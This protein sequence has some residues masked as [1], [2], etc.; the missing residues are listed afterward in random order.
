M[1]T[2]KKYISLL[3]SAIM[4]LGCTASLAEATPPI[5]LSVD[6]LQAAGGTVYTHDGRVTFV[7]GTCA[8]GPVKDMDAA[9]QVV[10]DMAA[11]LGCDENTQFEPWRTVLDAAGNIYYVFQ[12]MYHGTTVSGGAVKVVTDAS[13]DMLGL[14]S[15]VESELPDVEAAEGISAEEAEA[16]VLEH[17]EQADQPHA[18][19]IAGCTQMA[20]LPVN[21]MLDPYSEEEKEESRFVWVVYTDNPSAGVRGRSELP[22]LAHYV[23]TGG[24]YLYSLPTIIPGDEA[25][26]SGYDAS[27]VFEFMEPVDYADTVQLS[28]GTEA[29]ISVTLMRDTRTGMY[30]MGNIERRIVVADCYEFLYDEGRVV[31]E[32]SP[33]NTGWDTGCLLA[34]CNYCR[35]WDF[36]NEIGWHGGDGLGT[37][38]LIL[39]DYCNSDREPI[40]NAAYAGKYYGWQV[41]LS[42]SANDYSQCLDVLGHEFTHCVTGSVM[43]YNA[44]KNDYGAINEAMSDIMGNICEMMAGDTQDETWLLGEGS[45][46][47]AIRSM[48]DPHLYSQPEYTWDLYYKPNVLTPTELNDRG[49]VHDNSSLLN[50]LAY[51]LCVN[52]GMTL[53]EARAFWFAVDC[54]MVPGTDYA[55]LSELLPWVL[56]NQGMAQYADALEAGIDA[57]RIRSNAL[58]DVFD[59][60][61]ALVTLQLPDDEAFTDGNWG[62]LIITV[63]FDLIG[64]RIEDIFQRRGDCADALDELAVIMGID[65]AVM[66]TAEQL[67]DGGDEVWQ[68]LVD[69]MERIMEEDEAAEDETEGEEDADDPFTLMTEWALE[70]FGDIFYVGTGSAGQD[71]RTVRL[72]CRPGTTLPVLFRLA[73]DGEMHVESVGLA[74]YT[75]GSWYD[76]GDVLAPILEDMEQSDVDPEGEGEEDMSW[77]ADLFGSDE[78]AEASAEE[79]DEGDTSWLADLFGDDEETEAPAEEEDEGDMSWLADL[80]GGG[81]DGAGLFGFGADALGGLIRALLFYEVEP[82][83]VCEI[84]AEGLE[85]VKTLSA[86]DYPFIA[87]IFNELE[88]AEEEDDEEGGAEAAEQVEE[89]TDADV[90][91][92][93]AAEEEEAV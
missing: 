70:Y 3:L 53:E 48:S 51:R 14:V 40:D 52:G 29:D 59:E 50:N 23:T 13:G 71:G 93:I 69:A 47:D 54:A 65:P 27:Y 36:Y 60:D 9:A 26:T 76:L 63:N 24:E 67:K 49:G 80:F 20:V 56:E 10:N 33:D 35:A 25:G 83:A 22:Y 46:N 89:E 62:L 34:L 30:Y 84:P 32:Y 68:P 74:A 87:D 17:I 28:D 1:Y 86:E 90:E 78:E 15:S 55:Q 79:E 39:K 44:Y 82:G 38:I 16:K 2:L 72:V 11:L 57:T 8:T 19:V 7:D 5:P 18:D 21:L 66:P 73:I 75:L 12:Q 81:E 91:E 42:S 41:F 31:L 64:E 58:P 77:L 61:R 45:A 88:Q 43:T 37:P 6:M 85:S 4:L 92:E